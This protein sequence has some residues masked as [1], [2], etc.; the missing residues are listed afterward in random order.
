MVQFQCG[1]LFSVP[2]VAVVVVAVVVV[3][4][5]FVALSVAVDVSVVGSAA[6][7]F[8]VSAVPG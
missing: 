8:A 3:V 5:V 1:S 2:F 6:A 7:V 4:V